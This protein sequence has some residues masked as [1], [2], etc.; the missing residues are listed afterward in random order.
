VEL[1]TQGCT[2]S[3]IRNERLRFGL[4]IRVN[5]SESKQA[6]QPDAP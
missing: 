3:G 6:T 5:N 2:L 4:A 1:Y